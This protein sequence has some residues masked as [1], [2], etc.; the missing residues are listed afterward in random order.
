MKHFILLTKNGRGN[1]I[2]NLLLLFKINT[3][4]FQEK[5]HN[6]KLLRNRRSF[7]II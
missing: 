7:A 4:I 3:D 6:E 2:H 5:G 1:K